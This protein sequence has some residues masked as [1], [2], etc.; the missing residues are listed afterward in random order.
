MLG[1]GETEPELFQ[2]MDDLRDVGCQVL[3]MGQYLRPTQNHPAGYRLTSRRSNS[4]FMATSLAGQRLRPRRPP[5]RWF[6][7]LLSRGGLSSR[8]PLADG[9]ARPRNLAGRSIE[10]NA[11][12]RNPGLVTRR[13]MSGALRSG[14]LRATRSR[15]SDRRRIRP[16]R[17]R[18]ARGKADAR[19]HHPS[20]RTAGKGDEIKSGLRHWLERGSRDRIH[21]SPRCRRPA[22]AGGDQSLPTLLPPQPTPASSLAH[23]CTTCARCRSY[24]RTGQSLHEPA[25]QPALRTG[26]A[27]HSMRLS[28]IRRAASPP[29]PARRYRAALTTRPRCSIIASHHGFHIAIRADQHHLLRRSQQHPPRA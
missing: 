9:R 14:R 10:R 6:P 11:R 4:I 24:R 23:G 19:S 16:T 13:C 15:P 7:Q 22:F 20:R 8:R 2:A 5:G 12:G 17:P 25:D 1:L 18:P 26:G 27:R 21:S 3:T 29:A 28:L